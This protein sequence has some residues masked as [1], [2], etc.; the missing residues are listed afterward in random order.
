MAINF[1]LFHISFSFSP[2]RE[3]VV[4]TIYFLFRLL[5]LYNVQSDI[6]IINSVNW[7]D[8]EKNEKEE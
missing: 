7:S 6:V 3:Y 8:N 5:L 1:T 2:F 4:I